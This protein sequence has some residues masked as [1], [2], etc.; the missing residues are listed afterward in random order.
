ME[1]A[2]HQ[3]YVSY[4][5]SLGY[6]PVHKHKSL[7]R[8]QKGSIGENLKEGATNG[9]CGWKYYDCSPNH[10]VFFLFSNKPRMPLYSHGNV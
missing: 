9:V 5:P 1:K 7:N 2:E 6:E 8:Q 10:S 3:L 4:H